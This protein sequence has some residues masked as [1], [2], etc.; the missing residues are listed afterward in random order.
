MAALDGSLGWGHRYKLNNNNLG[1]TVFGNG[2][3][4]LPL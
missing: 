1:K 4:K 3:R 2:K